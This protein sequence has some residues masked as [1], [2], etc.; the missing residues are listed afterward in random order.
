VGATNNATITSNAFGVF[1]V[2][3]PSG[4]A[5]LFVRITG[6]M[7][8]VTTYWIN[9]TVTLSVSSSVMTGIVSG[10]LS[11]SPTNSIVSALNSGS[12]QQ[13]A[14]VAIA[15]GN[16]LNQI[17]A[18]LTTTSSANGS[19]S[20]SSAGII[21]VD[22]CVAARDILVAAVASFPISD[23]ESLKLI[24]SSFSSVTNTVGQNSISSA[25]RL[26]NYIFKRISAFSN[27]F[28]S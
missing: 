6:N 25:V 1:T 7:G 22:D 10:L 13:T 17:S 27:F 11:N 23:A 19:N 8:G 3:L 21:S 20:T 16:T 14:Q 12:L 4:N 5:T 2:Q 24:S 15:L 18:V 28:L 26:F 9:Q